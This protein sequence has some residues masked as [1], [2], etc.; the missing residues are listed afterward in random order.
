[1]ESYF[2]NLP[3]ICLKESG[4]ANIFCEKENVIE[5]YHPVKVKLKI[6]EILNNKSLKNK[7][8]K[9][10]GLTSS[11]NFY[12]EHFAKPNEFL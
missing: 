11:K 9:E 5:E 10:E 6:L 4:D 3:S 8:N 2:I 1:M 7:I 12:D